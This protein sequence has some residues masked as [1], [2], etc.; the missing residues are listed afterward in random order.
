MDSTDRGTQVRVS[1]SLNGEE[2]AS[3]MP[4]SSLC[5]PRQQPDLLLRKLRG[6]EQVSQRRIARVL[7]MQFLRVFGGRQVAGYRA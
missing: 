3:E 2:T 6:E 7:R 5:V 1:E 4:Q